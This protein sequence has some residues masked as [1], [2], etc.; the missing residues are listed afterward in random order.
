MSGDMVAVRLELLADCAKAGIA[1][2]N[3]HVPISVS[4]TLEVPGKD[5]NKDSMTHLLHLAGLA[6][7]CPAD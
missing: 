2:S 5:L 4:S 1:P 7:R 6:T 3:T